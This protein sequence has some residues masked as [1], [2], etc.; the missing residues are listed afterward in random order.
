MKREI[1][2]FVMM[3]GFAIAA[4]AGMFWV[5]IRINPLGWVTFF[6]V[7]MMVGGLLTDDWLASKMKR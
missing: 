4:I 1:C 6:G 3:L 5:F 2:T 7:G